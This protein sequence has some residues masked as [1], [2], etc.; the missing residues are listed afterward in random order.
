MERVIN[1]F[2]LFICFNS[3][4]DNS[5][6][7]MAINQLGC[8]D[9]EQ[10]DNKD[11]LSENTDE[12]IAKYLKKTTWSKTSSPR[13]AAES[14]KLCQVIWRKLRFYKIIWRK[15]RFYKIRAK[16]NWRKESCWTILCHVLRRWSSLLDRKLSMVRQRSCAMCLGGEDPYLIENSVW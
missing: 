2:I 15:L 12:D 7:M 8:E 4:T 13:G 1:T 6:V 11:N 10:C 9:L 5:M 3:R 16:F 14:R